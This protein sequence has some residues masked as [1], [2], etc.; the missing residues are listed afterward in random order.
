MHLS[1]PFTALILS[2]AV[3]AAPRRMDMFQDVFVG[4]S[5]HPEYTAVDDSCWAA[6][7]R[8]SSL[9]SNA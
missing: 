6:G 5:R 4:S 8:H 3:A 7:G 9:L 1:L 2:T